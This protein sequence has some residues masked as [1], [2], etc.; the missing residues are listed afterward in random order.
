MGLAM[1]SSTQRHGELVADLAA[2]RPILCEPQVL[3]IAGLSA[4]DQARLLGHVFDMIPVANSA[5]LRKQ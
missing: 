3:S 4:T 2:K 1:V 5:R